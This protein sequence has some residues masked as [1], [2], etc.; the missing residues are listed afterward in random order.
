MISE[1][2]SLDKGTHSR[3]NFVVCKK[4]TYIDEK[5]VDTTLELRYFCTSS[6]SVLDVVG[7]RKVV[8]QGN[9]EMCLSS[10]LGTREKKGQKIWAPTWRGSGEV[11]E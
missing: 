2:R 8:V 6:C 9:L 1:S 10:L 5:E 7:K 11:V 3:A 4:V